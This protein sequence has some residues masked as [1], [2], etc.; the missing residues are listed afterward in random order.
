MRDGTF[1]FSA[2]QNGGRSVGWNR[3]A[4]MSG[5][6]D[7]GSFSFVLFGHSLMLY[8]SRPHELFNKSE[9]WPRLTTDIY[10]PGEGSKE[11]GIV[12]KGA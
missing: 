5:T 2:E 1:G 3:V 12:D 4:R 8:L 9:K 6:R 7:S 10:G 11:L